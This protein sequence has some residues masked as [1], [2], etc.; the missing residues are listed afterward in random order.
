MSKEITVYILEVGPSMW[1][2]NELGKP[3]YLAKASE[4]LELMLH[5]K[6]SHVKKSEEFALVLFGTDETRNDLALNDEYQHVTVIR[7]PRNIDLNLL[8]CATTELPKGNAEAD[9]LDALIVG[10]DLIEQ[11]CG[12]RKFTKRIVLITGAEV[13]IN[14]SD[15]EEVSKQITEDGIELNIIGAG[16]EPEL[17][18]SKTK[19]LN[20]R[21]LKTLADRVNG[22][23]FAMSEAL[24]I[25]S[26]YQVKTV[27]STAA[28][29]GSLFLGDPR[30]HPE[31]A[32]DIPVIGYTRTTPLSL[33]SAKKWSTLADVAAGEQPKTHEATMGRTYQ[34]LGEEIPE[35][36][37]YS[38]LEK[39]YHYGRTLVPLK[40]IDEELLTLPA[41]KGLYILGFFDATYFN[42]EWEASNVMTFAAAP[43][44][45]LASKGLSSLIHAMYEKDAFALVRYCRTDNGIVKL[46]VLKP[47]IKAEYE[48]LYYVKVPFA[49]D[50][51]RVTFP[52]LDC[53]N[54]RTAKST[55]TFPTQDMLDRTQA[56][57]ESMNLMNADVD[58]DG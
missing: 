17:K 37:T 44:N 35:E 16:F 23:I 51:K 34:I 11:H 19:S 39:A 56:F 53:V 26:E 38:D 2:P 15:A 7:K 25:L 32:L 9:A 30:L 47:C 4:I 48:C 6:L 1:E 12:Q 10:I 57:I 42:R 13:P 58:K 43:D 18:K 54:K 8:L 21:F 36:V 31:T 40:K 52:S 20:E 33:P 5:P 24:D 29:R 41:E 22:S 45:T 49:E 50:I 28:F 3:T 46:G 14:F 55:K 27:R